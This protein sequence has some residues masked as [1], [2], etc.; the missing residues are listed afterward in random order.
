MLCETILGTIADFPDCAVVTVPV[1]WY[2]CHKKIMKKALENGVVLGI[3]LDHTHGLKNGD[4]LA[5]EDGTAYVV[6]VSPCEALIV[7]AKTLDMVPKVCYEIGNRHAPFFRGNSPT[8]FYTPYEMP[9]KVMLQRL[10]VD[11]K[12][13]LAELSPDRA[14]SSSTVGGHSHSHDGGYDGKGGSCPDG[15]FSHHHHEG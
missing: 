14:I 4:V 10:G 5:V 2:E 13:G 7:D 6:S 12:I 11:V 15:A 3:R 1:E 8:E 9:V